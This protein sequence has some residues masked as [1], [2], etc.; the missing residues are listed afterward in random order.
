M[1]TPDEIRTEIGSTANESQDI[2]FSKSIEHI[3]ID[4]SLKI[5]DSHNT[6][7]QR[8]EGMKTHLGRSQF[9]FGKVFIYRL[10]DTPTNELMG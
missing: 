2:I 6:F 10:L 1:P 9:L 3:D 5:V 7:R 8:R 4:S